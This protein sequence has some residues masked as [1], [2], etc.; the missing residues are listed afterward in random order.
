MA[1]LPAEKRADMARLW[2]SLRNTLVEQERTIED[3]QQRARSGTPFEPPPRPP[4]SASVI[5]IRAAIDQ[6]MIE[7]AEVENTTE[8]FQ[9]I[10]SLP[11]A[12]LRQKLDGDRD[13]SKN[14]TIGCWFSSRSASHKDYVKLNLR[15]TLHPVTKQ[16][17]GVQPYV[18]QLAIVADNRGGQ[19]YA[20]R[21]GGTHQVCRSL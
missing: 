6:A 13:P 9:A 2:S 20:A 7:A 5:G 8:V 4:S 21:N 16:T 19:L 15:N 12:W 18:H 17:I 1:S 14:N 10:N 11:V 3:L